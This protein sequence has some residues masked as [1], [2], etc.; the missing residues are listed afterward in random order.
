MSQLGFCVFDEQE[1]FLASNLFYSLL[2]LLL[3][4]VLFFYFF[5]LF[6]VDCSSL[7]AKFPTVVSTHKGLGEGGG[8]I[9]ISVRLTARLIL[10]IFLQFVFSFGSW[11]FL[12]SRYS[13]N[14][15][16]GILTL[17]SEHI[18]QLFI[19]AV[20]LK[21]VEEDETTCATLL[22]ILGADSLSD[23]LPL[24]TIPL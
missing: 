19:P 10:H 23:L 9:P 11:F 14:V 16:V 6:S 3:S 7:V 21:F 18:K 17:R 15:P 22:L 4:H 2:L 24:L 5:D 20:L 1:A 8:F 12:R 13:G